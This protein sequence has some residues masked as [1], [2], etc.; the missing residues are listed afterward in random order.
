MA[1]FATE[2]G[3]IIYAALNGNVSAAVYG[4]VPDMEPGNPDHLM[5]YL[6]IGYNQ[7]FPFDTDDWNGQNTTVEIR[8]YSALSS[9]VEI[10]ALQE[11]VYNI[12]HKKPQNL[13]ASGVNVNDCLHRYSNIPSTNA[14]NYM[15]G[16]S[17]YRLTLTE[18]L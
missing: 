5:P 16:I 8:F 14:S 7:D 13:S 9:H 3:E 1:G 12:L 6:V 11:E 17:R 10:K 2:A 18:V 15:L 4:Y